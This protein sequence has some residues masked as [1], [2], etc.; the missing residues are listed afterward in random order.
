MLFF[1]CCVSLTNKSNNNEITGIE[2]KHNFPIIDEKGRLLYYDTVNTKIY[3]YKDLTLYQLTYRNDSLFENNLVKSEVRTHYFVHRKNKKF[4]YDYDEHKRIFTSKLSADSLFNAEW[5]NK[6]NPYQILLF[7]ESVLIASQN[8]T[9]SGELKETYTLKAKGDTSMQGTCILVFKKSFNSSSFSLSKELDSMK[10]MKLCK[11]ELVNNARFMKDKG[12][13]LDKIVQ[14]HTLEKITNL[15][16]E[17]VKR[18]FEQYL[19]DEVEN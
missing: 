12:I 4:G 3:Y 17:L 9:D 11:F 10:Q 16:F 7:N 8:N 19:K 1:S 13:Y 18:Y 14:I 5:F 6:V 15:N 2:L